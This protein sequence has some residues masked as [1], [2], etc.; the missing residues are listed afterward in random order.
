MVEMWEHRN[1]PSKLSYLRQFAL[2]NN[3]NFSYYRSNKY[4]DAAVSAT[5]PQSKALS[6]R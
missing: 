5:A 1:D 3:Y 2:E 4:Q 6:G